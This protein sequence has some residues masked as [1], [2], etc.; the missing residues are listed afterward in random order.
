M[1]ATISGHKENCVCPW[2]VVASGP[3]TPY[4][5]QALSYTTRPAP[6]LSRAEF[7]KIAEREGGQRAASYGKVNA[8]I[9]PECKHRLITVDRDPGVTPA[10][11]PCDGPGP[12]DKTKAIAATMASEFYRVF[13]P[14]TE[15]AK[16]YFRP[17]YEYYLQIRDSNSV[18]HINNGGLLLRPIGATYPDDHEYMTGQTKGEQND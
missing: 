7:D 9:C 15:A 16:E 1:K 14:E 17:S 10:F 4:Y 3:K 5:E 2:C 11:L 8:Y 12:H 18:K 6:H 13:I